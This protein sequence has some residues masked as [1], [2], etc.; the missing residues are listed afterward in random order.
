M[1]TLGI[2]FGEARIGLA[3]SDEACRI[4]M[5]WGVLED[6]DKGAQIRRVADLVAEEGVERVVVGIPYE[7]DG[8]VGPMAEM[9]EKYA[10]KLESVVDVPVLRYDERFTSA[11]AEEALKEMPRKKKRRMNKGDVDRLAATFLLRW[12]LES[13]EAR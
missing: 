11:A 7:L 13:P 4:A 9:A 3:M 1:R 8:A 6:K 12:F 10:A 5:P 2:D